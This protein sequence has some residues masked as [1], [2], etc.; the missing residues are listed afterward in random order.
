MY[1]TPMPKNDIEPAIRRFA[2]QWARRLMQSAPPPLLATLGGEEGL[3]RRCL[4]DASRAATALTVP[5]RVRLE[6]TVTHWSK[7]L[8]AAVDGTPP[9]GERDDESLVELE[10]NDILRTRITEIATALSAGD[11]DGAFRLLRNITVPRDGE[12]Q[13][14]SVAVPDALDPDS[15]YW[16]DLAYE[17]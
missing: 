8:Q 3:M 2:G 16:L 5:P 12:N 1:D 4:R 7:T 17:N 11:V 6:R 15:A 9:P 10:L 14:V 13:P